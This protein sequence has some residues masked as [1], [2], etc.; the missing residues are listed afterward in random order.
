V[1]SREGGLTVS[2]E[3]WDRTCRQQWSVVISSGQL[4]LLEGI[5]L[6]KRDSILS[7]PSTKDQLF[8]SDCLL[9]VL[10]K[11]FS[12]SFSHFCGSI[13]ERDSYF[14]SYF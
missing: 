12:K 4:P 9:E 8:R 1:G 7:F 6:E 2:Q 11:Y 13:L 10:W 3:E 14:I 5:E